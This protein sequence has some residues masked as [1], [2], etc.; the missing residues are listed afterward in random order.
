MALITFSQVEAVLWLPRCLSTRGGVVPGLGE[1]LKL[2]LE[3]MK[4]KRAFQPNA[5]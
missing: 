1:K 4:Q 2:T 3:L 5:P